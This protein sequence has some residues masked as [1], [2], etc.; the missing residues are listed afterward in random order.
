MGIVVD[1]VSE[2]LDIAQE[3]IEPCPQFGES[4]QTDYIVGMGK[5]EGKVVTLLGLDAVLDAGTTTFLQ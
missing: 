1:A 3:E 5:V 4:V 2:V